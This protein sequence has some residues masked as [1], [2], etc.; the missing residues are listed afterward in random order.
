MIVTTFPDFDELEHT[1]DWHSS[2]NEAY[3]EIMSEHSGEGTTRLYVQN[4][5]G[6]NW[7]KEGGKWP[8]ICEVIE[9]LQIDIAC[10]SEINTDTNQYTIRRA[11][12]NICQRHFPKSR[13]ISSVS[14]YETASSYKPGGTAILACNAVT[15]NIQSHSRDR[16]GRWTSMSFTTGN[17]RRVRVISAYQVCHGVKRGS[18]TAAS[19]QQ[20]QLIEERSL[21][22]HPRQRQPRQAFIQDLQTFITQIQRADEDVI[23]VG[24]FNEEINEPSSGM[25]QLATSC[26]L[27]DLFSIRIGSPTNP[28]TYQRGTRQIDFILITPSLLPHIQE[29]GYDPF[30]Y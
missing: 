6:L 2:Q 5:N 23:L 18:N 7:D 17:S 19:H 29:A 27:A 11:M 21:D 9:G 25:D 10:F 20:A 1:G 28:A 4:V 15:S 14:K 16:M 3:G 12:E 24:D 8:Y 26:G 13:L 22:D 30:G